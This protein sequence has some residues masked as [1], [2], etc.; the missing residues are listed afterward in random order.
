MTD[1]KS[2]IKTIEKSN[3]LEDALGIES[4]STEVDVYHREPTEL[5]EH[6]EY[7]EKDDEIEAN[8]QDVYDNAMEGHDVLVDEMDDADSKDKA[9]LAELAVKHLGVALDASKAK[10]ALKQHKDKLKEAKN[11]SKNNSKTVNNII[12]D[13]NELLKQIMGAT[14]AQQNDVIEGETSD[15]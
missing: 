15:E 10:A 8:F 11:K 7:D 5:V 4:G 9:K 1:K 12:I 14:Q 6:E 3:P 13:R 2:N